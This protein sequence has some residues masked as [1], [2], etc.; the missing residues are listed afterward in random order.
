META[1][2]IKQAI[3]EGN[4]HY[5]PSCKKKQPIELT[6]FNPDED[7]EPTLIACLVCGEGIDFID[8]M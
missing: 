2:K 7:D 3:Y 8:N 6:F 5:C 1:E 4:I